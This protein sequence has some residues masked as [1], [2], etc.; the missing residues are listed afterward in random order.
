VKISPIVVANV[1]VEFCPKPFLWHLEPKGLGYFVECIGEL[2]VNLFLSCRRQGNVA[3]W[4]SNW[5]DEVGSLGDLG[6]L[7]EG[8][9]DVVGLA[10]FD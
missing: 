1:V 8:G 6:R 10:L 3:L 4:D 9:F 5:K 2:I 7:L